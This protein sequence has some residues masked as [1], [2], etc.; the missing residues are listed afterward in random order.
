MIYTNPINFVD[1]ENVQQNIDF[2]YNEFVKNSII[3]FR[4]ANLSFDNHLKLQKILGDR[5]GWF[6]NSNSGSESR[7]VENHAPNQ[8]LNEHNKDTVVLDWHIEHPFFTNPIVGALWNMYIFNTDENNGKTYFVDTRLIY[9]LLPE[10]WKEFLN[11]SIANTYSYNHTQSMH[12]CKVVTPHWITGEPVI[13][14]QLHRIE[15]GW[16]DLYQFDG[17]SP[18]QEEKDKFIEIATWV[19]NEIINNEDIRIVHKWKQG[20]IVVPDLY[21]LA[22]AIT[23]GFSPKDREFTG[24]WSYQMD[25]NLVPLFAQK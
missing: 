6:P 3:V 13:R 10:D 24:L 1:L 2:Y 11:K 9:K 7:Y 25:N 15:N 5:F 4:N 21:C 19:M 22:H 23:G 17:R 20:D 14:M 18:T 12:Q 8:L 16:H